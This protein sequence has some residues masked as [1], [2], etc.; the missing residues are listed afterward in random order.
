[1]SA[2]SVKEV[3]AMPRDH[4]DRE[5]PPTAWEKD[6]DED[7]RWERKLEAARNLPP[8]GA[9]RLGT[10][11]ATEQKVYIT[12]KQLSTHMHVVGSS[13]VGKSFF[14]AGVIMNLILEGHGACVLDPHGDLYDQL[15]A[16]CAHFDRERPELQLSRRVIPFNIA[17]TQRVIGFNPVARNARVMTYQ[18]LALM[19]AIRKCW[20]QGSFQE[21]PRLARWLYNTN[22]AVVESNLTMLQGRHLISTIPTPQR[23]AIIRMIK[24]QD[25]RGEWQWVAALKPEKQ[26]ERLESCFNRIREFVGNERIEL[27]LGQYT[28]TLDFPALLHEK[29]IL[30][31]NLSRQ[32]TIHE[33]NQ[34]LLGTLIVNELL[35]AAFARPVGKR[36]PFFL[37]IDEFQHFVTK[38]MCEILDGGR[39]YG[40]HLTLSHQHL[41]QT[42]LKD[43]E[44]YYSALTNARTKVVMGGM[45]DEDLEILAKELFTGELDPNEV[46]DEIWTIAYDP[47]ETT[48][49][50]RSSSSGESTSSSYGDVTHQSLVTGQMFIPGSGFLSPQTLTG[51][52]RVSG[53]ASG[54][55]HARG[56]SSSYSDSYAEVP[57]F[58]YH[59]RPQL[60]SRTFRALEEQLY[61]KKAQL[62]RQARQHAALLI[63]GNTVQWLKTPTLKNFLELVS[64]NQRDEFR[65]ACIEAARCYKRPDEARAEIQAMENRLLESARDRIVVNTEP[66]PAQGVEPEP[67]TASVATSESTIPPAAEPATSKRGKKSA[68]PWDRKINK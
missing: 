45:N 61:I 29:K 8:S 28:S 13:G 51:I 6:E 25:I 44:V 34:H 9:V 63:P 26:E 54:S 23:N 14:L 37:F 7:R 47:V 17:E 10:D 60:A 30:L 35:T 59:A 12:P 19:E 58:E 46:K 3:T 5:R 49:V 2:R 33:D 36:D 21:T 24:S 4:W 57:W 62:K 16:F 68:G 66:S 67:A 15:L 42:K 43:P 40:L 55:S 64:E 50:I 56:S 48:R 22:Y 20:G 27:M 38:D 1:M 41:N 11:I 53:S 65:Q 31:V 39:K 18:V 52:S 32:N